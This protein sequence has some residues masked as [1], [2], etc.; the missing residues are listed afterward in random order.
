LADTKEHKIMVWQ[1]AAQ[2]GAGSGS[3]LLDGGFSWGTA[4][5]VIGMFVSLAVVSSLGIIARMRDRAAER[6][7]VRTSTR[8]AV[9][10]TATAD[11]ADDVT[12][13]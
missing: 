4:L 8:A 7:A 2:P 1:V 3:G 11:A 10:G 12:G 6:R 13:A 5:L 9:V